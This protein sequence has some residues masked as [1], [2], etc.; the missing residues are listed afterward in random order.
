MH[1]AVIGAE[2]ASVLAQAHGALE[3]AIIRGVEHRLLVVTATRNADFRERRVPRLSPRLLDGSKIKAVLLAVEV[4]LCLVAA[5]ERHAVAQAHLLCAVGKAHGGAGVASLSLL[6]GLH[7]T[8]LQYARLNGLRVNLGVDIYACAVGHLLVAAHPSVAHGYGA[9]LRV[10]HDVE[11]LSLLHG[12]NVVDGAL[13][14]HGIAC[15]DGVVCQLDVKRVGCDVLIVPC[16]CHHR[17]WVVAEIRR[18]AERRAFAV[19]RHDHGQAV[20]LLRGVVGACWIDTQHAVRQLNS[21]ERWNEQMTDVSDV[22][23]YIVDWL[24]C[25]CPYCVPCKKGTSQQSHGFKF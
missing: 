9:A 13:R 24:L 2:I 7:L 1:L 23:I 14:C 5:Y 18:D 16:R 6:V 25:L 8:I 21:C 19:V 3:R 10:D 17:L 4:F 11:G 15:R 22:R 20:H 12:L